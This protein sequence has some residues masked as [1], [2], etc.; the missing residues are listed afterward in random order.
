MQCVDHRGG[1]ALPS[2]KQDTSYLDQFFARAAALPPP[3]LSRG[4]QLD[5]TNVRVYPPSILERKELSTKQDSYERN[6]LFGL[7]NIPKLEC[8]GGKCSCPE[9]RC[10]CGN[11]CDGCVGE[12]E[13]AVP[14]SS[15]AP[16]TS[17][18]NCC[19]SS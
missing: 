15:E 13:E 9:D 14:S 18:T 7:V 8:C 2:V 10:G 16:V 5:P 12:D 3:P 4:I 11:E 1:V 6:F 19:S 17:Q